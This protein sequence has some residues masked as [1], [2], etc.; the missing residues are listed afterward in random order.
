MTDKEKQDLTKV[1][2]IFNT[3][4]IMFRNKGMNVDTAIKSTCAIL[5]LKIPNM[6]EATELFFGRLDEI[7]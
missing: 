1:V 4:F 6:K 2:D 5:G 3:A 7:N